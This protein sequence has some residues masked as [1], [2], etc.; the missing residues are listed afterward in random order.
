MLVPFYDNQTALTLA[1]THLLGDV[2]LRSSMVSADRTV[3]GTRPCQNS[4]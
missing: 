2:R 4:L 1:L 3:W